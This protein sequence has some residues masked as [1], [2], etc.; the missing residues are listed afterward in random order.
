MKMERLIGI[1]SILLQQEKVT[2]PEL[3]EQFEVS[4]RTIQRD[5]ESLCGAGIPIATAQGAGG[6]ISIMEGYRVDRTV[7]TAPEMQAI[8]AGLRSLDSVS[9]TRRYAQLVQN[10]PAAENRADP[11]CHRAAPHHLFYL[12][13]SQG[14]VSA[15]R[16]A[17][18]S[19]VPLVRLVCVGLVQDA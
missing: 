13:L 18:L 19:G 11:E 17:P 12:L 10:Q 7:L 2:A 4:R 5:I 9:G 14:G 3:A 15:H 1:L 6:G 8:L 16:G